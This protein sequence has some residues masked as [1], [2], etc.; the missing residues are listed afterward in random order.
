[1]NHYVYKITDRHGNFYIG[2][3]SSRLD[4][5]SDKYMGSGNWPRLMRRKDEPLS[6]TIIATHATRKES[7]DC[8]RGLIMKNQGNPMFMNISSAAPVPKDGWSSPWAWF[9]TS[10]I[11]N[12]SSTAIFLWMDLVAHGQNFGISTRVLAHRHRITLDQCD[13]M[14]S[15]IAQ[16]IDGNLPKIEKIGNIW[17]TQTPQTNV[18]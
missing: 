18:R 15:E 10:A 7:C 4:P 12:C 2:S 1:M 9:L 6:K 8:E 16:K 3:R 11:K 14:L 13:T 17:K 5:D